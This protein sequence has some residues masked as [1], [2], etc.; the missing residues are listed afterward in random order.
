MRMPG[1]VLLTL[2]FQASRG[3]LAGDWQTED[4]LVDRG[5]ADRGLA[6]RGLAD[7]GLAD[8]GLLVGDWQAN[9]GLEGLHENARQAGVGWQATGS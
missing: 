5:L 4:W 6:D 3:T 7:R 2:N 8:R 9:R 1:Q